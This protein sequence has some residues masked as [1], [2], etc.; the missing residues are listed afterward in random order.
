MIAEGL[1]ALR[2]DARRIPQHY[3][4]SDGTREWLTKLLRKFRGEGRAGGLVT[5]IEVRLLLDEEAQRA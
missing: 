4:L 5:R 1:D 3:R 2:H